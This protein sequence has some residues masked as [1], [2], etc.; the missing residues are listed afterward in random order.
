[1]VTRQGGHQEWERLH[2]GCMV[3]VFIYFSELLS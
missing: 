2:L 3:I 1:M